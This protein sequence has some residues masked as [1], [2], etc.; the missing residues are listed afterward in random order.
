M[1]SQ[2]ESS[3]DDDD[4]SEVDDEIHFAVS[5]EQAPSPH[6]KAEEEE[7]SSTEDLVEAVSMLGIADSTFNTTMLTPDT[8]STASSSEDPQE[9]VV[10]RQKL[11]IFLEEC[12]V[13]P[14]GRSWLAWDEASEKTRRR[15]IERSSEVISSVINTLSKQNAQ[16]LWKS[17]QTSTMVSSALG[18]HEALLPAED[19]YLEALAEAYKNSASWDARRQVLSIMAGVASFSAISQYIP[20]LTRYRYQM[21]TLHSIQHGRGVPVIKSS[22][23]RLRV[24]RQQLDHFL[25]FITSPHLIQDLPFG[26]RRLRLTSGKEIAVPNVI[27]IMIPQ[28]IVHQY[29]ELCA[30]TKFTPFSQSTVLRVLSECSATVRRSLQGLDY[31]AAEGS[32]A[33]DDLADIVQ[34]VCALDP[35][36]GDDSLLDTLKA[37]KLYLKGDFKVHV[38]DKSMVADHCSTYALSDPSDKEL[39]QTCDH[40]HGD[41]CCH[42]EALNDALIKIEGMVEGASFHTD[43]DRDEALYMCQTAVAARRSWKSH[44][45]RSVRQ[46]QGRIDIINTL[47]SNSVLIVSDWAMKFIP[48]RYRESQQD[49]FGKRGMSWHIAVVFRRVG[50][51]LQSQSFVHLLLSSTQDSAAVVQIWQHV[52]KTL[53]DDNP[54]ITQAFLR[55]DNAGCYHSSSS[56]LAV[57]DIQRSVGIR[58]S[59]IDFSDPQGGKGAANRLAARCKSHIRIYINEGHNVT[60]VEEMKAALLS[61]GGLE[62]V[63]VAVVEATPFNQDLPKIASVNKLNNFEYVEGGLVAW[64]AYGVSGG[65]KIS[66]QRTVTGGRNYNWFSQVFTKGNFKCMGGPTAKKDARDQPAY[67]TAASTSCADEQKE[68]FSCPMDDCVRVFQRASALDR[69]LCRGLRTDGRAQNATRPGERAVRR[70]PT[71]GSWSDSLCL[72]F[73]VS[74]GRP[75]RLLH[76][77]S[78]RDGP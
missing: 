60:T 37:G 64:R 19:A 9:C 33:F 50:G 32:R 44:Q 77:D 40:P 3:G 14:L 55:Q 27:R 21:A 66:V 38:S 10:R 28:R 15:Y 57:N 68:M 48:Q 76:L 74:A 13:A 63:R 69:H 8:A 72:S 53:N 20:G 31:Y 11:N 23:P 51:I 39:S 75:W 36:T 45:L 70:A 43:E 6:K 35:T 1:A 78:L 65:K 24:D 34:K 59:R 5:M 16:H 2:T 47:D 49:W 61:H 58:V 71:G 46:D 56:I 12:D 7:S 73:N 29:Q 41:K 17:L 54:E 67:A 4:D 30:E 18:A 22:S 52:L 42:C 25:G 62:G 26:E